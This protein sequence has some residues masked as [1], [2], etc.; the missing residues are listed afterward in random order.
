MRSAVCRL[1]N[2]FR[3]LK[4]L[5]ILRDQVGLS[6][7]G[8]SSIPHRPNPSRT[9]HVKAQKAS[10]LP[11]SCGG[12]RSIHSDTDSGGDKFVSIVTVT[13][14]QS[15]AVMRWHSATCQQSYLA[16]NPGL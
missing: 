7:D 11:I 10:Q 3:P 13:T 15:L 12:K 9:V 2:A 6:L 16:P 8:R 14:Q 4:S 5:W 1:F